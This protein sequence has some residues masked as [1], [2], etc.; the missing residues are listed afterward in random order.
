MTKLI[1]EPSDD[2]P[3]W[4]PSGYPSH[5]SLILDS[6]ICQGFTPIRFVL[7]WCFSEQTIRGGTH[8]AVLA[9]WWLDVSEAALSETCGFSKALC[10]PSHTGVCGVGWGVSLCYHLLSWRPTLVMWFQPCECH[11]V[12]QGSSGGNLLFLSFFSFF[13]FFLRPN[14]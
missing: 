14:Q 4:P 9:G 13:F 11:T 3:L 2:L 1:S 7:L 8:G 12:S 10:I 5:G 6:M